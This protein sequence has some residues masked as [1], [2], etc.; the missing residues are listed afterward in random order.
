[1]EDELS[2]EAEKV[3]TLMT[4]GYRLRGEVGQSMR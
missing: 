1:M 4:E 3:V 2:P